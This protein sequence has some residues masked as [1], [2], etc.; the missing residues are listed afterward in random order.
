MRRSSWT[1][2]IVP[3]GTDE[4][5]YLVAN[6]FGRLG[7]AWREADYEAT[8]LETVIQD[9]LSGQYSN[10]FR[11][12]AFNT[13]ERWSEDV[14]EEVA[15]EL[16]RRCDLQMCELPASLFDFVNQHDEPNRRQL[17]LRLA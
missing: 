11:V 15:R 2:S 14:S 12:I 8:D 17:T 3:S 10:P 1:P 6:D 5:V 16:R 13:A 9:L 4:T 7:R